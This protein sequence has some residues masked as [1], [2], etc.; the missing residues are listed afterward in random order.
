MVKGDRDPKG[1]AYRNTSIGSQ[2][3][4]LDAQAISGCRAPE[5]PAGEVKP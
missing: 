4:K 3:F 5:D 2:Y 1:R